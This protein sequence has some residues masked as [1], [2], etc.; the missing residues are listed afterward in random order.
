[1]V[2]ASADVSMLT[3]FQSYMTV[4]PGMLQNWWGHKEPDDYRMTEIELN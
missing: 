1:M 3:M 2:D 4:K